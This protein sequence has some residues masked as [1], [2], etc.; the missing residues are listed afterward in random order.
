MTSI[1]LKNMRDF[2]LPAAEHTRAYIKVQDG[3][4]QF[5][6]LLY[7]SLLAGVQPWDTKVLKEVEA[8]QASGT[9]IHLILMHFTKALPAVLD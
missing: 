6:Q 7:H 9:D 4:N 8:L 1:I 2:P 5:L 3:C